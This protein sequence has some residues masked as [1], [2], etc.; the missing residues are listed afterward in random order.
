MTY[1]D[2]PYGLRDIKLTNIAGDSQVDLP[3][4]RTLGFQETLNSNTLRG[5]DSILAIF[6]A[7]DSIEWSLEA[8]GISLAAWALMTGRTAVESGSSPN[9]TNT[10]TIE[11]GEVYPYFKIY[12]K[13]MGENATDD[14]HVKLFKCKLTSPLEGSFQ[15]GEFF[16]TSCSGI[17]VDDGVNGIAEV[18]QNETADDLPLT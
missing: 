13:S 6:A 16:V 8:G 3:A 10:L 1:G 2:K 12:G 14:V 15:D 5:D 18:V 11:A 4:A 7:T 9:R 17:A